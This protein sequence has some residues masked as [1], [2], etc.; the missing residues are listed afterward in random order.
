MKRMIDAKKFLD[1]LLYMGY[2]DE[3]KSEVEEVANNMTEDA[4]TK[5]EVITMLTELQLDLQFL[6][7]I[8]EQKRDELSYQ[9]TW[10][11]PLNV[12]VSII[13]QKINRLRGDE[14]GNK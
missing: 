3:Q 2:M 9:Q 11:Y 1:K 8:E 10:N 7:S 13:Q 4:Y 6:L 5:D 14:N 12:C